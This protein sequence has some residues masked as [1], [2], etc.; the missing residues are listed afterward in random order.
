MSEHMHT[1]GSAP[2]KKLGLALSGGGFRA[3]LFHLGVLKRMAE[4]NLLRRVEV[5][6][7]VSGGSIIGALYMLLLKQKM[8]E[9]NRALGNEHYVEIIHRLE[10]T[11]IRAVRRNLRNRLWL[12]PLGMLGV[13][14]TPYNLG[15]RMAHLYERYIFRD[16]VDRLMQSSRDPV[17]YAPLLWLRWLWQPPWQQRRWLD[18]FRHWAQRL[19]PGRIRLRDIG[20]TREPPEELEDYNR[21][22]SE[23]ADG[24]AL[25]ELIMNATSVNSGARFF[26]SSSEIGDWFLG[27]FRHSE[28][29]KL[30]EGREVC[31]RLQAL[32]F[33]HKSLAD[34]L[35]D[36]A[37]TLRLRK[38]RTPH[39]FLAKL[40]LWLRHHP[41][42]VID[43]SQAQRPQVLQQAGGWSV[44]FAVPGIQLLLRAE[45]GQL[46]QAKL[47]AAHHRERFWEALARIDAKLSEGLETKAGYALTLDFL[48]E[49]YALRQAMVVSRDL[50]EDWENLTLGT[51]V[52]CSACFPPVFPPILFYRI[53]ND[54]HVATLGLTDGGVFDNMGIWA[55]RDEY[56]SYVIVSDAGGIY[57]HQ[58]YSSV[59]RLMLPWRITNLLVQDLADLHQEVLYE[60]KGAASSTLEAE[61]TPRE[62]KRILA[63]RKFDEAAYFHIVSDNATGLAARHH[64]LAPQAQAR[65]AQLAQLRQG[66]AEIRT[67]L[68]GFGEEEIA[69]LVNLGY[70]MA[71]TYL[72]DSFAAQENFYEEVDWKAA[73]QLPH[74]MSDAHHLRQVIQVGKHRFFRALHL[75]AFSSCCTAAMFLLWGSYFFIAGL[76]YDLPEALLRLPPFIARFTVWDG[77]L[78]ASLRTMLVMAA[79]MGLLIW[80]WNAIVDLFVAGIRYTKRMAAATGRTTRSSRDVESAGARLPHLRDPAFWKTSL[81]KYLPGSAGILLFFF[82]WWLPLAVVFGLAVYALV[83]QCLFHQPFLWKTTLKSK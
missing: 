42:A 51:A 8:L 27:Y 48:F 73:F 23:K 40:L 26:F 46:R 24:C 21:E 59:N 74:A 25:T 6:S 32:L 58:R 33:K 79:A 34:Y 53:Y 36:E 61:A 13:L 17:S 31:E 77:W 18:P 69:A 28:I 75:K 39:L 54:S 81:W 9:H 65:I 2:R 57:Q 29:E 10:K 3:S 64:E 1:H 15:E 78:E 63:T 80:K 38:L 16:T 62:I 30:N 68:D 7:T 19:W 14:L 83:N 50:K 37:L 55:L 47:A 76:Q 35:N 72:Y 70:V 56:C 12:N 66:L 4:L 41:D 52:S 5:L 49:L 82:G 22:Q 43:F 60:W 11:M 44:I 71:D 45:F 67:D 20:A